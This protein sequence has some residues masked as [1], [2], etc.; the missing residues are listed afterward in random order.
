MSIN[1][2]LYN[3]K[4]E[5]IGEEKVSKRIFG[6]K[7][8]EILLHQVAVAQMGNERQVLAD[9]KTRAEVRGG[10]KKPWRQ[11]GTGRARA[12]SSRSPIWIGGGVAFGPTKDRNFKK[13]INI[14]MRRKAISMV[15]TDRLQSNNMLLLDKFEMEDFKTKMANEMLK[16]FESLLAENKTDDKGKK[17]KRSLLVLNDKKDEKVKFSVRN[18][19]GVE[20]I[21]INNINILDLLKYK[22]L[23]LTKEC[24]KMI[25]KSGEDK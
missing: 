4:A 3:Q 9:T 8:N 19:Q 20:I 23:V 14:K 2:K 10:G 13:K 7:L 15:L 21:N 5:V 25:E 16:K 17:S 24:V 12:G 1:I 18:L 6:V 11:K 22:N